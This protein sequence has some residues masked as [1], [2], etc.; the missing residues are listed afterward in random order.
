MAFYRHCIDCN[1]IISEL[2]NSWDV[3]CITELEIYHKRP[4]CTSCK[5]KAISKYEEQKALLIIINKRREKERNERCN[6]KDT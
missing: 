4:V 6:Q 5:D 1:A 3:K 2:K